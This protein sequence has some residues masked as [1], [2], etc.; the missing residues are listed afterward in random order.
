[1][2]FK[3]YFRHLCFVVILFSMLSCDSANRQEP[4]IVF[5]ESPRYSNGS[6]VSL[7]RIHSIA[8]ISDKY[9]ISAVTDMEA[10]NDHTLYVLDGYEKAIT[11]F[12]K[13]GTFKRTMGQPGQGPQDLLKP[14][15]FFIHNSNLY[16]YEDFS[17]KIW[18]TNG[19]YINRIS[20]KRYNRILRALDDGFL[21]FPSERIDNNYLM[22][23][24]TLS[25][26]SLDF[27]E[28]D[29][30]F[31]YLLNRD[32]DFMF[33]PKDAI[34]FDKNNRFYF[35]ES[36]ES[37]SIVNYDVDGIPI[38]TIRRKYKRNL[39]PQTV[40]SKLKQEFQ[41]ARDIGGLLGVPSGSVDYP[42]VIRKIFLDSRQNVWVVS[43]E[44]WE[45]K[46]STKK[47]NSIDIFVPDGVWLCSFTTPDV[48][49]K[50]FVKND[51]LYS[52]GKQDPDTGQQYINV[53]RI[54]YNY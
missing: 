45:D 30:L 15:Y 29:K 23:K 12:D 25:R 44:I 36:T 40:R 20:T 39:Y 53:Y 9:Y 10:D 5:S 14:Q 1:M 24:Y 26:V 18:D 19:N 41:Q 33:S 32:N 16:I 2:S 27:N 42:P 52:V 11:V 48:S 28:I 34:A 4:R 54:K 47:E 50:S 3:T 37:Y 46:F 31:S 7:E 43:G 8:L 49:L 51:R 17:L 38:V 21:V 22:M 6:Y 35:P 13:E